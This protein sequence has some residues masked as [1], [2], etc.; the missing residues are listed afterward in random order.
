MAIQIGKI[1]RN[2]EITERILSTDKTY[3]EIGEE[4]NL[5][6]GRVNQLFFEVIM[7]MRRPIR[8]KGD[9]KPDHNYFSIK[10][11]RQHKEF[12]LKQIAK[13]KEEFKDI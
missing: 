13:M 5:T 8:L 9:V 2:I 4:F 11:V 10:E 6:K 3:R 1:K 12:W 7:M